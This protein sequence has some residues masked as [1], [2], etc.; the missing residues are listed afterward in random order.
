[1][2][3]KKKKLSRGHLRPRK[4]KKTTGKLEQITNPF[5]LCTAE[6]KENFSNYASSEECSFCC[7][8]C[9]ILVL[10]VGLTLLGRTEERGLHACRRLQPSRFVQVQFRRIYRPCGVQISTILHHTLEKKRV[11]FMVSCAAWWL[12]SFFL[13]AAFASQNQNNKNGKH[14]ARWK[15]IKMTCCALPLQPQKNIC[16]QMPS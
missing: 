7:L 8:C 4:K 15:K 16:F 11:W 6:S 3:L 10:L 1:M 13:T 2:S 5:N 9:M 12:L 14:M